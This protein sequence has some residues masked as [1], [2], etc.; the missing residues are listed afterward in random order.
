[1]AYWHQDDTGE[2]HFDWSHLTPV[3]MFLVCVAYVLARAA[4][5]GK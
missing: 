2:W 4:W 5:E 1:M 3:L